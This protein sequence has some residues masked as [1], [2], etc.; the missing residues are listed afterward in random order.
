MCVCVCVCVCVLI[1]IIPQWSIF[2][3]NKADLNSVFFFFFIIVW[4]PNQA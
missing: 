3:W 2:K 4:L 1:E